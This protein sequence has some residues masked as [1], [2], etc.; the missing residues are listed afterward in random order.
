[1]ESLFFSKRIYFE[2]KLRGFAHLEILTLLT[3]FSVFGRRRRLGLIKI[4]TY[5][6]ARA[7]PV[8]NVN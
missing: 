3:Y 1:M 8:S 2:I 6:Q 4:R 7:S 5:V